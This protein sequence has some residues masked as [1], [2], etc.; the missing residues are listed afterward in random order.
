MCFAQITC[1]EEIFS[2]TFIIYYLNQWYINFTVDKNHRIKINSQ[3][4]SSPVDWTDLPQPRRSQKNLKTVSWWGVVAHT[5]NPSTWGG[6]GLWVTWGQ[7][8]ETSLAHKMEKPISTKYTKISWAW[9]QVPI[10][11]A[12]WEAEVRRIAWTREVEIAVSWEHDTILQPRWQSETRSQK[13]KTK[14]NCF[15]AESRWEVGHASVHPFPY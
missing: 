11:P 6:W 5:C 4:P 15:L 8:F 9:W 2:S 12:A 7:E 14:K 10:I 3:A 13:I 1:L